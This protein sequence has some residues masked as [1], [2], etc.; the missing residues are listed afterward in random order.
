MTPR[1]GLLWTTLACLVSLVAHTSAENNTVAWYWNQQPAPPFEGGPDY[2]HGGE[3]WYKIKPVPVSNTRLQEQLSPWLFVQR[4]T[5]GPVC[6]PYPAVDS[7]GRMSSGVAPWWQ[8]DPQRLCESGYPY[9]PGRTAPDAGDDSTETQIYVREYI[10]NATTYSSVLVYSFMSPLLFSPHLGDNS[11]GYPWY[12]GSIHIFLADRTNSSSITR[13]CYA[14]YKCY[15]S[16]PMHTYDDGSQTPKAYLYWDAK[17][18]QPHVTPIVPA[19][20]VETDGKAYAVTDFDTLPDPARQAMNA[21]VWK[22][23]NHISDTSFKVLIDLMP[24][25]DLLPHPPNK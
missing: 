16:V 5:D 12:F 23:D 19:S 2:I 20:F 21:P 8:K 9:Y 24:K 22:Y 14:A 3:W 15:S 13:I 4:S 7:D 10:S 17:L 18:N 1:Q 6:P 25:L 11:T